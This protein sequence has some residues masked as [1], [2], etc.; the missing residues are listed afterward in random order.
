MKNQLFKL[1]IS[2]TS[3][4]LVIF[5]HPD[6][7]VAF[8]SGLML[9]AQKLGAF[10]KVIILTHGEASTLRH[11]LQPEDNLAQVRENEFFE[12]ARILGVKER[13]IANFPDKNIESFGKEIKELLETELILNSYT[14][15]VTFE[16]FGVYGHPD[17]IALSKFVTE[18]VKEKQVKNSITLIYATVPETEMFSEN[19]SKMAKDPKSIKPL[20]PNII[21]NL[22]LWEAVKKVK[23][24]N[25]N[26]SQFQFSKRD[27]F[28]VR[29]FS[30]IFKEYFFVSTITL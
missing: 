24:F 15:I 4:I 17:H 6:D 16:P 18:F 7:E 13:E 25:A 20:A 12:S 5:P 1:N 30:M 2:A 23:A 28:K 21:L 10:V 19:T 8:A 27:F 9:K 11:G 22:G 14:H 26:K 29:Q 3:K